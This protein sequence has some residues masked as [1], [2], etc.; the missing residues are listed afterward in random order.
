MRESFRS[1]SVLCRFT[2]IPRT[3]LLEKEKQQSPKRC[4][5]WRTFLTIIGLKTFSSKWPLLPPIDTA[6]W[7]P[8]T[9]AATIV[10]ASGSPFLAQYYSLVRSLVEVTPRIRSVGRIQGNGCHW[11]TICTKVD[12]IRDPPWSIAIRVGWWQ[13]IKVDPTTL[14]VKT[15][16]TTCMTLGYLGEG[17]TARFSAPLLPHIPTP[18]RYRPPCGRPGVPWLT[19]GWDHILCFINSLKCP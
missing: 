9:L 19:S 7:F 18:P 14:R 1:L 8:M 3:Q 10:M 6:V 16:S 2:L 17:P 11:E 4:T 12:P 13:W 5:D 15:D